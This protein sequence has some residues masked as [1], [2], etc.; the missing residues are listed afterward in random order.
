MLKLQQNSDT[1]QI[2]CIRQPKNNLLIFFS[3]NPRI[4]DEKKLIDRFVTF[5][6]FKLKKSVQIV[7]FKDK[8]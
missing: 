8:F 6:T 1:W 5:E 2:Y 7:N 4:S 3:K